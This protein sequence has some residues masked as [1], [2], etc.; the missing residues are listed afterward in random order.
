MH[1]RREA[2]TTAIVSVMA[3]SLAL[4]CGTRASDSAAPPG[5][6]GL[7]RSPLRA[8]ASTPRARLTQRNPSLRLKVHQ[9]PW[10]PGPAR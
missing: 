5:G 9:G 3:S 8:A 6:P 4:A 1:Q 7:P 2:G 10:D